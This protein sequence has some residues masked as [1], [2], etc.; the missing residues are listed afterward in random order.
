MKSYQDLVRDI[1]ENGEDTM[2]RTGV[3]TRSV[4]GRVFQHDM[5]TGFPAV[6]TK[7]LA[8]K[9]VVGELLWFMQGFTNVESL[10][11][12]TYGEGSDKRTIWDDNYENQ[13]KALGYDNGYL[14]PVYGHQ[15]RCFGQM[16]IDQ[17]QNV[18]NEIKQNPSS[19]RLIVS[20]WNPEDLDKMA[21]PPC[22]VLY[23]FSVRGNKLNLTWYQR[24]VDTFLG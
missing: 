20:A 14:G 2:D 4:I 15:W 23:R 24:S 13:A 8:W 10:R 18:V 11:E 3:G 5:S 19:R 6:T 9:A 21:L 22:H 12:L 1:L 17:L 7:R 16:W